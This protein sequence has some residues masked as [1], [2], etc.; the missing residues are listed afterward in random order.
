LDGKPWAGQTLTLEG[1]QGAKTE[2]KTDANGKYTFSAVKT[3]AY[4]IF[5]M[6][7]YQKDPF[8][9][10]GVKVGNGQTVPADLN[11]AEVAKKNPEYAAAV[12]KANEEN[13]K[14]SGMKA[15]FDAGVAKLDQ[16]KEK[17]AALAKAPV[18]QRDTL[19]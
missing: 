3:G 13:K 7:P 12:K 10:A 17:K 5:V 11:M 18:D 15:H 9:A 14:S 4:K 19:K 6:L 1:E 2:T 16:Y 8:Q